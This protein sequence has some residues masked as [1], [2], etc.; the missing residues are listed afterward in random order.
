MKGIGPGAAH[1]LCNPASTC[2]RHLSG[3]DVNRVEDATGY[4]NRTARHSF[5]L[6]GTMGKKAASQHAGPF[7]NISEDRLNTRG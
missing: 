6:P 2:K 1:T 5:S 4:S 3:I 7:R